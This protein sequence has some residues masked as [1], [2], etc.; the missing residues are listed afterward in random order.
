MSCVFCAIAAGVAPANV[1]REWPD[2]VAFRPLNPVTDGHTLV[3]PR[4]HVDDA[5]VN[6]AVTA[7]TMRRAAEL[8]EG[9]GSLNLITSV[10]TAATQTVFHL[11][12]HIVPREDGDGLSLPWTGQA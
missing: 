11:H 9:A 12:I 1:V 10:G 4:A 6:P 7:L 8:A 2:A 5:A 3:I